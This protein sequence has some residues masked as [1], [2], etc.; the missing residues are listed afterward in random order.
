MQGI[1]NSIAFV[2]AFSLCVTRNDF[3]QQHLSYVGSWPIPRENQNGH[4]TMYHKL[5]EFSTADQF[6]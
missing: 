5:A 4:N 2:A 3:Y 1:K 6:L